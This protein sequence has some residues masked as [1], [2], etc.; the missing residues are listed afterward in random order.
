MYLV[1]LNN[2]VFTFLE[3]ATHFILEFTWYEQVSA[4]IVKIYTWYKHP[5]NWF[6]WLSWLT[7]NIHFNYGEALVSIVCWTKSFSSW[8]NFY[9][10]F[11]LLSHVPSLPHQAC[12]LVG[13]NWQVI[14]TL[15]ARFLYW[16]F[17]VLEM[18]IWSHLLSYLGK[19]SMTFVSSFI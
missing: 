8:C 5:F 15:Y 12:H 4:Y 19:L 6:I 11:F 7:L 3:I 13:N 2:I 14:C 10:F 16:L 9:V 1:A 17:I 18:T